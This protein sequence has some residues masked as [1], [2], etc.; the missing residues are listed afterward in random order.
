MVQSLSPVWSS[1]FSFWL[2]IKIQIWLSFLLCNL[3][4]KLW[5]KFTG[6]FRK[7]L[8]EK[9]TQNLDLYWNSNIPLTYADSDQRCGFTYRLTYLPAAYRLFNFDALYHFTPSTFDVNVRAMVTLFTN[10]TV[11]H[12]VTS[13]LSLN[14][15]DIGLNWCQ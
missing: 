3:H 2:Q 4:E 5:F 1:D 11:S 12:P 6:C 10:E 13:F 14:H 15:L 7:Y 8:Q 9:L